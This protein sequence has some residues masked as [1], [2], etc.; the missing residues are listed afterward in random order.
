MKITNPK[1]VAALQKIADEA[2]STGSQRYAL[3]GVRLRRTDEASAAATD[4]RILAIMQWPHDEQPGDSFERIVDLSKIG[5]DPR[6]VELSETPDAAGFLRVSPV[7]KRPDA[8]FKGE[9]SVGP[10]VEGRFPQ[11]EV[12]VPDYGARNAVSISVD[13]ALLARLLTVAAETTIDARRG[14]RLTIP[15]DPTKPIRIDNE[16]DGLTFVGIIMPMSDGDAT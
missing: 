11:V 12:C 10:V 4:G 13:P 6:P 5:P 8:P 9:Y 3:S 15:R 16:H 1:A 2:K 14:V 7:D